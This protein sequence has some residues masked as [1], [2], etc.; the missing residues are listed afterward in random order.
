MIF[1]LS[2]A[3]ITTLLFYLANL[4]VK[5]KY[6]FAVLFLLFVL[7]P[8]LVGGLRDETVGRDLQTYGIEWFYKAV[9]SRSFPLYIESVSNPEYG[10]LLLN[11]VCGSITSNINFFFFITELLKMVLLGMTAIHFRKKIIAP[12]LVFSYML[13]FYWLGLSMMRQSI[14]LCICLYSMTY[15]FDAKYWQ[16]LLLCLIAYLF[17]NSAFVFLGVG[18]MYWI[19]DIRFSFL[20]NIAAI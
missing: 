17:H 12:L 9:Y 7:F 1:Y 10:Y 16:F 15:F 2:V 20:I 4:S 3:L 13:Y 8:S 19:K 5:N 11:Y 18:V 6:L 14:A